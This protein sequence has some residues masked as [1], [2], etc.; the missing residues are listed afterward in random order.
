MFENYIGTFKRNPIYIQLQKRLN[1][2]SIPKIQEETQRLKL[3]TLPVLARSSLFLSN[4]VVLTRASSQQY[5]GKEEMGI[6][7]DLS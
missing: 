3:K 4:L 1:T 6:P 5:I 7:R 2:N